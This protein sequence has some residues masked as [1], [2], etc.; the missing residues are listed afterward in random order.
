MKLSS[1]LLMLAV[2]TIFTS[3]CSKKS[4][5]QSKVTNIE[6]N[7]NVLLGKPG[8][9]HR[10][11]VLSDDVLPPQEK[12]DFKNNK[13]FAKH[14]IGNKAA[15][16][17]TNHKILVE[18]G[19]PSL[20]VG[21]P[22][23]LIGEESIFGG[24]IIQVSDKTSESLGGLKL[25]DLSPIHV[26]PMLNRNTEGAMVLTLIGCFTECSET[27]LP[28]A[29]V[30]IP[31]VGADNEKGTA[32][33]DF[34][35][36][37]TELDLITILDP[38]GQRTKLKAISANVTRVEFD[39]PTLFFDVQTKM[40]PIDSRPTDPD[41]KVTEFTTRWYLR[42]SSLFDP[43]FISRDPA[44]GVGFF[45]TERAKA[46]KITRFSLKSNRTVHY[47]IKNVP[48]KYQPIYTEAFDKWNVELK[49]IIGRDLLSYSILK[50][51]DARYNDIIP[52]DIRY[53]VLEWDVNNRASYG[54]LGPSIANQ[55]TGETISANVLI[56]GP[57]IIEMY[58][59]WFEHSQ[60][61]TKL[62]AEGNQ[63]E[64]DKL[65]HDFN[66]ETKVAVDRAD[67]LKFHLKLGK[68]LKME[69]RSQR[70]ELEDPAYKGHFEIVPR[71]IYFDDYMTGYF[72]EMLD[73]ELGHNLGLRHNFKGNLGSFET[74]VPGSVSR[75]IMEYLGRPYRH[76]NIIGPYDRMAIAYGYTGVTPKELT[77]YCTD[78][79]EAQ[80]AKTL[81]IMSAECS[82]N[83]ATN[84]PYTFW[85]TRLSRALDLALERKSLEAPIW[86]V[87]ELAELMDAIKG[88]SSYAL[89]A[90][91][92]ASTWTNFFGRLDRPENKEGMKE[93]VL[94]TFNRKFCDKSLDLVVSGKVTA[95]AQKLTQDNLTEIRK[96]VSTRL[97]EF[98]LSKL[99]CE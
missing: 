12:I 15:G 61:A 59:K 68:K 49:K 21:Y 66:I 48:E 98:G 32:I 18:D 52:G 71:G 22:I 60:T 16:S 19:I 20:H 83:D 58:T 23:G 37:G 73:H 7:V 75:S 41:L 26:R 79:N 3:A 36:L 45:T 74:K 17:T 76:L 89:G 43:T 40:I 25:T 29:L 8:D 44:P 99:N 33:L 6:K 77:W 91:K 42:L 5:S 82:K 51:T 11:Q 24:V 65:M 85:E 50:E 2:L 94:E 55:F 78:E 10:F 13:I 47:Y 95:E 9:E 81:L 97:A 64:A 57:K 28:D 1:P 46:E 84:D 62:I 31:I 4:P 63:V 90:E 87:T 86:K 80:D 34:S 69:V 39:Q 72:S 27:S 88:L 93:F 35:A 30:D 14:A 56:Q 70:P 92:T 53:N 38:T 54:G 67:D 96:A